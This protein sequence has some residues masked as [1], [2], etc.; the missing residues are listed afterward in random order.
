VSWRLKILRVNDQLLAPIGVAP[1][2]RARGNVKRHGRVRLYQTERSLLRLAKPA[3]GLRTGGFAVKSGA[4]SYEGKDRAT[5]L[6]LHPDE[7]RRDASRAARFLKAR[8]NVPNMFRTLAAALGDETPP[9]TWR[10]FGTPNDGDPSSRLLSVRVSILN[11]ASTERQSQAPWQGARATKR[12]G[13]A[14]RPQMWNARFKPAE[15][16]AFGG[17]RNNARQ[18]PRVRHV[19]MPCC[20][21]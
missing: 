2:A 18:R 11:D 9:I 14:P 20:A 4:F 12:F 10:R 1:V 13:R 16:A 3:P 17:G 19:W 7:R 15:A 8:N 6:T 5:H 21:F